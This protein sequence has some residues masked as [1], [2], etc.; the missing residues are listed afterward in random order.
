MKKIIVTLIIMIAA[1]GLL[2]G[3]TGTNNSDANTTAV[4]ITSDKQA[5]AAVNDVSTDISGIS[6]TLNQINNAFVDTNA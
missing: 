6:N 4:K 3:C 1:I 5:T 2:F